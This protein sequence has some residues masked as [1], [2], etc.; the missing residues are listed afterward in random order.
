MTFM[1]FVIGLKCKITIYTPCILYISLYVFALG[2]DWWQI[3]PEER[4]PNEAKSEKNKGVWQ[5]DSVTL[6]EK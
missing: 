1:Y 5:E 2:A 6:S 4:K 3:K